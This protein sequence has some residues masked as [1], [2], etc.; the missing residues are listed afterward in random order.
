[1]SQTIRLSDGPAG[2]LGV[3]LPTV[4]AGT[5]TDVFAERL[6]EGLNSRGIRA[7][8][9]WLPHRSE[10]LPWTV[11]VPVAP[12]WADI[13]H[14]NTWIYIDYQVN[15]PEGQGGAYDQ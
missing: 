14:V 3:W 9:A 11:S 5:G 7:E 2:V 1:M 12:A 6:C 13:V 15:A 8:I 4:R 10:Y